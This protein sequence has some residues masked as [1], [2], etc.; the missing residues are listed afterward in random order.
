MQNNH[1]NKNTKQMQN[2]NHNNKNAKQMQND[3][4]NNKNAKQMQNN[5]NK[6]HNNKNRLHARMKFRIQQLQKQI[7]GTNTRRFSSINCY[8]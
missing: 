6:K 4:N 7:P 3:D 2:N 1:N 5:N 8:P